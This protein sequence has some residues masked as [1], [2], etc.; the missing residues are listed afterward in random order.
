MRTYYCNNC[1]KTVTFDVKETIKK[2][3]DCSTIF[4]NELV[5]SHEIN[6]RTTWSGTTKMEFN[7]T[8]IGDSIDRMNR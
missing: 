3:N 1:Q 2:C 5:K 8:T 4:E 7:T 6:M